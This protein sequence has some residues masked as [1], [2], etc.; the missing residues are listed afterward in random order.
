[1]LH[2]VCVT[3]EGAC[4]PKTIRSRVPF[5]PGARHFR[6]FDGREEIYHE[7]IPDSPEVQARSVYD[8]KERQLL[9]QWK[10]DDEK[11]WYL[12]QWRD[13]G[14]TWRCLGPR[15]QRREMAIPLHLF[16]HRNTLPA[17]V[18]ATSGIATGVEEVEVERPR[19]APEPTVEIVKITPPIAGPRASVE[20]GAIRSD[21]GTIPDADLLWFDDVGNEIGRGRRIDL[22]SYRPGEHLIRAV[23]RNTGF[24]QAE[25]SLVVKVGSA[26]SSD[27]REG[28]DS[29]PPKQ[30]AEG[31]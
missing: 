26:A 9:V 14:G 27:Q 8:K 12:V 4:W 22:S 3:C 16:G 6:V 18:L 31:G 24:G 21:G 15:T 2:D 23:L 1:M 7:T 17:R 28:D 5:P 20:I 11:L 19:A 29:W 10:S 30:R 25:R 13:R